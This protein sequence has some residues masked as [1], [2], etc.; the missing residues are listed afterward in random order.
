[1]AK[2]KKPPPPYL[3]TSLEDMDGEDWDDVVGYDGSYQVSNMGR[4]KSVHRLVRNQYVKE[5][6]L[7]QNI[8]KDNNCAVKLSI[9]G[10]KKTKLVSSLVRDVFFKDI[11]REKQV[12]IHKNEKKRRLT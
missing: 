6:I 3:N 2:Q 8:R 4:V 9:G 11:D 1:M 10:V 5:K 7:K 12:I